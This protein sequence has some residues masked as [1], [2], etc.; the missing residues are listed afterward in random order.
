MKYKYIGLHL[1][2]DFKSSGCISSRVPRFLNTKA[3]LIIM[4]CDL[5]GHSR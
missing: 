2:L 5:Q 3:T 1:A 4:V